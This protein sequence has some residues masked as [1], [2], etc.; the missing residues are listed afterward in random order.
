M[1]SNKIL[2]YFASHIKQQKLINEKKPFLSR[3]NDISE[4]IY[5]KFVNT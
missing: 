5:V 2:H 3:K 4:L 1:R